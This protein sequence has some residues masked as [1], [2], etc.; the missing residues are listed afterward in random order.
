V[1]IHYRRFWATY[2]LR[3]NTEERS[4]HLLGGGSLKSHVHYSVHNS[5]HFFLS[6]AK[7]IHPIPSHYIS[8]SSVPP[9]VPRSSNWLCP[10]EFT[11]IRA[12]R[13]AHLTLLDFIARIIFGDKY[14]P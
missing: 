3:N 14:K 10:A 12:P 8:F 9:F 6:G 1:V 13:P 5:H 2:L 7:L 11:T 4:S